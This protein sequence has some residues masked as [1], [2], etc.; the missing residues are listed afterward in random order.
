MKLSFSS[1]QEPTLTRKGVRALCRVK[2][3]GESS[4]LCSEIVWAWLSLLT[5]MV[6]VTCCLRHCE[7]DPR[8]GLF[9]FAFERVSCGHHTRFEQTPSVS[10]LSTLLFFNKV[11]SLACKALCSLG[12][13]FLLAVI[14]REF[15]ANSDLQQDRGDLKATSQERGVRATTLAKAGLENGAPLLRWILGSC[16]SV[17]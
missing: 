13:H 6:S 16:C 11:P 7:P 5:V 15:Q 3:C 8:R 9:S 4:W 12:I 10:F 2:G 1:R 17:H 14:L